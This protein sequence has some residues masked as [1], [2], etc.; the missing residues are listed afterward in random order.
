MAASTC[1]SLRHGRSSDDLNHLQLEFANLMMGFLLDALIAYEKEFFGDDN[2]P[3]TCQKFKRWCDN[4]RLLEPIPDVLDSIPILGPFA[5]VMVKFATNVTVN[6]LEKQSVEKHME[7]VRHVRSFINRW[8]KDLH[9]IIAMTTCQIF[10]LYQQQFH[11][12]KTTN[13]YE[14][15]TMSDEDKLSN[16][17]LQA[18]CRIFNY[19]HNKVIENTSIQVNDINDV[20]TVFVHGIIYGKSDEDDPFLNL[21]KDSVLYTFFDNVGI[22]IR[23]DDDN[24]YFYT[25]PRNKSVATYLFGYRLLTINEQD[26]GPTALGYTKADNPERYNKAKI[27]RL[28]DRQSFKFDN[29]TSDYSSSSCAI[30]CSIASQLMANIPQVSMENHH[31]RRSNTIKKLIQSHRYKYINLHQQQ[32]PE[33]QDTENIKLL[34]QSPEDQRNNIDDPRPVMPYIAREIG[35]DWQKLIAALDFAI[36]TQSIF[37]EMRS[38]YQQASSSLKEWYEKHGDNATIGRLIEALHEIAREDLVLGVK[39]KLANLNG[40]NDGMV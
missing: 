15:D 31:Q 24:F 39:N 23:H 14:C 30:V 10:H 16:L 22:A 40:D 18:T 11:L 32:Q 37:L 25:R 7:K 12:L 29:V 38:I 1:N 33:N 26:T 28:R 13:V 5:K 27:S 2:H 19:I 35:G 21:C 9:T 3:E 6:E 4:I 8:L 20:K 17:A 34:E 36:D